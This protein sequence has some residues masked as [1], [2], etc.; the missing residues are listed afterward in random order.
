M[1]MKAL[2][3]LIPI[4]TQNT[5]PTFA[6]E[7]DYFLKIESI[8]TKDIQTY[9]YVAVQWCPCDQLYFIEPV[10]VSPDGQVTKTEQKYTSNGLIEFKD[11]MN[12]FGI[13]SFRG[14]VDVDKQR[15]FTEQ[16]AAIHPDLVS[17]KV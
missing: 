4:W 12:K 13:K 2:E 9:F 7:N 1:E 16:L 15:D 14:F 11:Y 17:K 10:T 3:V 5:P 6:N 8:T